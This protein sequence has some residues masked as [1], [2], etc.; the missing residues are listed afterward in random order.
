[1][2][3]LQRRFSTEGKEDSLHAFIAGLV[4]GYIVFGKE[5]NVNQQ[6]VLYLFSRITLGVMKLL[7]QKGYF[8]KLFNLSYEKAMQDPNIFAAFSSVVWGIVMWL[9]R[10]HKDTLQLGLQSSMKYLYSD[11]E[12]WHSFKD[13]LWHNTLKK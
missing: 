5:S 4:G 12:K 10:H 8:E 2:M 7:A 11:S 1:L 13:W 9:F 6:I 3:V